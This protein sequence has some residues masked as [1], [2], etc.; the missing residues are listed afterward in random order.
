MRAVSGS[1]CGGG[2]SA[3]AS[4]AAPIVHGVITYTVHQIRPSVPPTQAVIVCTGIPAFLARLEQSAVP[5]E[6]R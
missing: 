6:F 3:S 4:M 2:G 5:D 1:V